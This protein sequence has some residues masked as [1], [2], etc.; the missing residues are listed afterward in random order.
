MTS[1]ITKNIMPQ[2]RGGVLAQEDIDLLKKTIE[3]YLKSNPDLDKK[4]EQK[5]SLLFHRLGRMSIK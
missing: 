1:D 5:I 3:F 4:E 2:A